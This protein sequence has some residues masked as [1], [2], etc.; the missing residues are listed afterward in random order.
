MCEMVSLLFSH[1]LEKDRSRPLGNFVVD[2]SRPI[3]R[4]IHS[5]SRGVIIAC[6]FKTSGVIVFAR[7]LYENL[8]NNFGIGNWRGGAGHNAPGRDYHGS[9]E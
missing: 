6:I 9:G 5:H 4:I 8:S 3:W 2:A 1:R 7:N